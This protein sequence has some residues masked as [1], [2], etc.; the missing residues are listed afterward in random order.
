MTLDIKH[1]GVFRKNYE[2]LTDPNIRFIIN[3]GGSRSSKT[4]SICQLLVWYSMTKKNKIVSV[5]RK[6]LP[7]LKASVFADFKEI[8][9][10]L[11]LEG[12]VIH[13]KS[14]NSFTFPSGTVVNFFSADDPQKLRG[15]KHDLVFI[16]EANELKFD[17]YAQLNMRTRDSIILDFNPS[18][19]FSYIYNILKDSKAVKIHST[20]KDNPFLEPEI[21][22]EIENY[23]NTD[24][25]Y[26]Q[27]YALGLNAA[28]REKIFSNI[29]YGEAPEGLPF[30]YGMDFGF[31]DPNTIIKVS[32]GDGKLYIKE[33]LY[34]SYLTTEDLIV[35]MGVL[36]IDKTTRI[37]ADSSR[38]DTIGSIKRAGYY[39]TKSN[40]K[41]T[42]GLDYMKSHKIIIDPVGEDTVK[43]FNNYS[44][45]KIY[46]V[47][48][49]QPATGLFDHAIDAARYAC[50]SFKRSFTSSFGVA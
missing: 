28:G 31:N 41:I 48:T 23:K 9:R 33:I 35:Q 44:Y 42:E 8:I 22:R 47:V 25:T 38:P 34:E 27:I 49:D 32:K 37:Y 40:K 26:Y 18:D 6:T 45:K 50:I 19:P 46:E 21:I 10:D 5:V 16:N 11:D 15:R 7:A 1:T 20:Y 17:E 14:N 13:S 4:Y 3:Q 2:A 12:I 36:G 43:E 24:L 29:E 30:V 39:I